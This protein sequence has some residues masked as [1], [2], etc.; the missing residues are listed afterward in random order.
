M[1][2]SEIAL[3]YK[4]FAKPDTLPVIKTSQ[5]AFDILLKEWNDGSIYHRESFAVLLLNRANAVLGIHW[6]SKGDVSGTVADPKIIFQTA[7]K[8]NAFSVIL[9]H[10]HPSGKTETITR[11]Y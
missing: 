6:V 2:I 7:L 11:G 3:F 8:S 10:N 5:T 9:A 1:I 4:P